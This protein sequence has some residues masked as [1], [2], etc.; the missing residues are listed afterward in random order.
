MKNLIL[1]VAL[2]FSITIISQAKTTTCYIYKEKTTSIQRT[3]R[4][5]VLFNTIVPVSKDTLKVSGKCDMCKSRIE[6]AAKTV[7][8]V[9]HAIWNESTG[10]LTYSYDANVKKEDVSDAIRKVGHDT[11]LGKAPEDAYN[12]LPACCKYR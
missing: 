7:S 2:F 1:V 8:G 10:I 6:N 3:N 9:H 12:K 4:S 5:D 11:S